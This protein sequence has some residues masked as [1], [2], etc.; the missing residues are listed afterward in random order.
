MKIWPL[1]KQSVREKLWEFTC[2]L[3]EYKQVLYSRKKIYKRLFH[4]IIFILKK[5]FVFVLFVPLRNS[6]TV[7]REGHMA[8]KKSSF[9]YIF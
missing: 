7:K 4:C 8:K 6:K 1:R 9:T 5:I 2:L 3:W